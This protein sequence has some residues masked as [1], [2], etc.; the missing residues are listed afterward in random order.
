METAVLTMALLL[1]SQVIPGAPERCW[2]SFGVCREECAK[3]ESFYIFCRNGKL[4]C[5]KPKNVPLWS[6]NLD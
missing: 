1:L 5:V 4:C 3:K 2:K 6:Q